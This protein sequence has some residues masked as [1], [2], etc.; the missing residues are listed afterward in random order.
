MEPIPDGANLMEIDAFFELFENGA[1]TPDDGEGFFAT[2]DLMFR[3]Y[4]AFEVHSNDC[5]GG[6]THV[7]WFSHEKTPA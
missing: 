2:K 5:I 7:A 6:F 4:R 1:L 3:N